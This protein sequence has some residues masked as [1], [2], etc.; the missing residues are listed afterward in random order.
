LR[1]AEKPNAGHQSKMVG[2][3]D[4]WSVASSIVVIFEQEGLIYDV[5]FGSE[6]EIPCCSARVRFTAKSGHG[7]QFSPTSECGLSYQTDVRRKKIEISRGGG[8]MSGMSKF[9]A[10]LALSLVSSAGFCAEE[11]IMPE[12]AYP[13][14]AGGGTGVP[15]MADA[16][17]SV[18]GSSQQLRPSQASPFYGALDADGM[19]DWFPERHGPMPV[20]VQYGRAPDA[21]A[22][23]SC[24]LTSGLGHPTTGMIAGLDPGYFFQQVKNFAEGRR[25]AVDPQ[26]TETMVRIATAMSDEEIRGAAEY[27]ARLTPTKWVE[28][29]EAENIPVTEVGRANTRHAVEGGGMEPL[30]RRIIE[31]PDDD[32]RWALYDPYSGFVA[33]VPIGSVA[34]GEELATAG[35]GGTTLPCGVCHGPDL[36]GIGTVPGIA[37]RLPTY[38]AR[39]MLDMQ[40]GSR[41]GAGAALMMPVVQNLD[42]D[43]IIDIAAYIASLEP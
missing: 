27:F 12:W 1:L 3:C 11:I 15:E 19:E 37:G 4:E 17:T 5:R 28:V 21:R 14:R 29:I 32:D 23:I 39:Q 10:G 7:L 2:S 33:Y 26:R 22:C 13:V 24:H 40:Q 34:R 36:K 35:G 38:I 18:P 6:A 16:P 9:L 25:T 41:D 20:V 31:V 30:G 43:G 8:M 42:L